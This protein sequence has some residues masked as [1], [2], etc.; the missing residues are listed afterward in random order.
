MRF[1]AADVTAEGQIAY[2]TRSIT[3]VIDTPVNTKI[4]RMPLVTSLDTGHQVPRG[5]HF[6]IYRIDEQL[7]NL[8]SDRHS[9]SGGLR[10]WRKKCAQTLWTSRCAGLREFV[11]LAYSPSGTTR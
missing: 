8:S 6:V 11:N 5:R 10:L 3:G 2:T 7:M 4:T 1:D 9:S